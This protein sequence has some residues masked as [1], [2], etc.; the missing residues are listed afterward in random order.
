MLGHLQ[1]QKSHHYFDLLDRDEDGYIE[2]EDFEIQADRLADERDL[3]GEAREALRERM[4]GWWNQLQATVD[5]NE[6]EQISRSE[7]EQF[8]DAIRASVEEGTE[9]EKTQMIDSLEQS[10]RVTFQTID[11]SG[12]GQVTEEEYAD[13]LAAWG[14]VGSKEAFEQLDRAGDGYLTKEDLVEATKEFYLSNDP[15]APGTMLYGTI[16]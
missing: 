4:L 5:T 14:A 1:R 9:E 11:A 8:W 16:Q 12:S 3:S 10:A 6:D 2:G 13:W 7:W 15:E